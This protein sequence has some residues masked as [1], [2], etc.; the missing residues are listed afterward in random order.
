M[1]LKMDAK[2]RHEDDKEFQKIFF[3]FWQNISTRKK[4]QHYSKREVI[5]KNSFQG[6]F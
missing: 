4:N 1:T 3:S 2:G 5:K 6:Y